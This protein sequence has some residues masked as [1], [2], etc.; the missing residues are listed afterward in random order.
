MV[1]AKLINAKLVDRAC[2]IF[3]ER[4]PQYNDYTQVRQMIVQAGSVKK[5]EDMLGAR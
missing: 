1:N 2:R 3:M 5:A 4:N